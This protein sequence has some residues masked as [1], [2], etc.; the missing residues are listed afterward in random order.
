MTTAGSPEKA[1]ICRQLGADL[2]VNYREQDVDA[3]VQ[4]FAPDGVNVVW[5]TMREPE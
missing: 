2:V 3:A 1:D 5:E 4:Q